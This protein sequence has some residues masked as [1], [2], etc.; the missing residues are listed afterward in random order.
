MRMLQ[1]PAEVEEFTKFITAEGVQNVLEIGTGPGGFIEHLGTVTN[2]EILCSVDLPG[3]DDPTGLLLVEQCRERNRALQRKHH[4]FVGILGDSHSEQ[5]ERQVERL[6]AGRKVDLLFLD[7]DDTYTG[8][9]DDLRRYGRFVRDGGIV[10]THD[11][12]SYGL[13]EVPQFWSK[14]KK[15]AVSS[16]EFV[17][18]G[19]PWG[20]IGAVRW[21]W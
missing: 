6:F 8:K 2:G 1:W 19:H 10:A 3:A 9:L 12:V 17:E 18:A 7:G 13:C 15:N 14:L 21:S 5:V 11:I 16:F 20:G 4:R